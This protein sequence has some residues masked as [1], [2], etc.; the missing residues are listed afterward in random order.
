MALLSAKAGDRVT[1]VYVNHAYTELFK[2]AAAELIGQDP[3]ILRGPKTDLSAVGRIRELRSNDEGWTET[4]VLYTSEGEAKYVELRDRPIDGVHRILSVRDLTQIQ[5]AQDALTDTNQRLQSLLANNTSAVLTMDRNRLCVD[6]NFAATEIFGYQREELLGSGF[7]KLAGD[8]IFPAEDML[9]ASL[10]DGKAR[11][12]PADLRHRDGRRLK[13]QCTAV[14][15]TVC[16]TTDGAYF[17]AR[18]VTEEKRLADLVH[19]QAKRTHAL[20]L[21]SAAT[22]ATNTEQIESALELVLESFD[23]QFGYVGE[24]VGDKLILRNVAGEPVRRVG[25]VIDIA[26]VVGK[27]ALG[28]TQVIAIADISEPRWYRPGMEALGKWHGYISA[29]VTVEGQPFG[30]VGF[31]ST[32]RVWFDDYDR[33]FIRLVAALISNAIANQRQRL[34]LNRLAFYDSLT[35]LQN[36]EKFMRD[37]DVTIS[38]SRRQRRSFALHYI[39]LDGFKGINDE[40]GHAV[41][42]A[43]LQEVA[44]RLLIA[45]R[46]ED[47]PA[48]IGGD[49]FILIQAD[50]ADA[51]ESEVLGNRIVELLSEPYVIGDRTFDMSASVGIAV[52]P[53]DGAD[54]PT[55]LK[56]A[57][58]ALYRAKIGGK[59]RVEVS[60]GWVA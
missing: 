2:Y 43:A 15:I 27:K 51:S 5:A 33:D 22:G 44:R 48:R 6:A 34:R 7:L 13:L 3:K 59:K 53:G 18:D 29:P 42:D 9:P 1:F 20:Y 58:A 35:G 31:L 41:G 54:A 56:A 40:A 4:V 16:D 24:V 55:L 14:P 25:S 38:L 46:L 12:F 28:T 32:K 49:E 30:A 10:V 26:D 60:P 50:V 47:V 19:H 21:I 39:D 8:G 11:A 37:L 36:R 52:F 23:M 45:G 57:D 17:V